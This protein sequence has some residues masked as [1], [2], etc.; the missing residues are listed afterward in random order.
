MGKRF[1]KDGRSS[2]GAM[3]PTL[4]KEDR[5][6]YGRIATK[7]TM[8]DMFDFGYVCGRVSVLK[9]MMHDQ[10]KLTDGFSHPTDCEECKKNV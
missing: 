3:K 5:A 6:I 4:S 9:E 1:T 7:G 10:Q 2:F 8:S